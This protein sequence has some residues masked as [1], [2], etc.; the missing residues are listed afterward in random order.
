[1]T[2]KANPA[3]PLASEAASVRR[4]VERFADGRVEHAD[5]WIASE[6]PI[7][8]HFNGH[9]HVVML[10]TPADLGDFAL[11]FSLSEAII[12]APDELASI[13]IE[14]RL[15][16]IEISLR[17]PSTRAEL[18]AARQRNLTGTSSCGLCGTQQ[19]EDV[20]RHPHR[21]EAGPQIDV[22][23]LHAAL[24]ALHAAQ[25]LNTRTG[26]THAAAW[27]D[28]EGGLIL[29]REDVG[30]HN[31]LDKLI[32]AMAAGKIDVGHGFLILT[33]RASYEMVQKAA[34]VGVALVAAISAPTALAIHLAESTG[35]T[36][37]GFAR[38]STH[39]V[40]THPQR[41]VVPGAH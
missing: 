24:S 20:V 27:A 35:V 30:R 1:M 23:I 18:I 11:G 21:V 33:S 16:G 13:G 2:S 31:A 38:D 25:P 39:V 5:D 7:A 19:L 10:A 22:A 32:G 15:E 6:V 41:L 17:I 4:R 36:L 34:T 8:L 40:Y 28:R 14:T 37:V 9:P 3:N 26:A 12:A 29:V